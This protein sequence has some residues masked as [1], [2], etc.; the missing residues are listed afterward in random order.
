MVHGVLGNVLNQLLFR[1]GHGHSLAG[2][3]KLV[4]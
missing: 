4:W 1:A 3:L 2:R